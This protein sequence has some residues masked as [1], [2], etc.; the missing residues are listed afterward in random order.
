MGGAID[1]RLR[2]RVAGAVAQAQQP[3][4]VFRIGY[5]DSSTAAGSAI[6]MDA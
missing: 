6:S 3:G 5:L 2:A 1:H 4:K